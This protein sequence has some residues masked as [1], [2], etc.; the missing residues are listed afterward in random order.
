MASFVLC[1]ALVRP[2][3]SG[4]AAPHAALS[5]TAAPRASAPKPSLRSAFVQRKFT[6][7]PR[8]ARFE[9]KLSSPLPA[10][11]ALDQA[12]GA[13]AAAGASGGGVDSSTIF[14]IALAIAV[15]VYDNIK[16]P[17]GKKR[18]RA[19]AEAQEETA[20]APPVPA[21]P[22]GVD[23]I[24][25]WEYAV[26]TYEAV[27]KE[28]IK[29]QLR[30]SGAVDPNALLFS[31]WAARSGYAALTP[32]DLEAVVEWGAGVKL[33]KE[34]LA[35]QGQRQ[36]ERE[37]AGR[38]EAEEAAAVERLLDSE[39]DD[40]D[41]EEEEPLP[42]APATPPRPS[43]LVTPAG[44]R[45]A[46]PTVDDA[47]ACRYARDSIQAYF[48]TIGEGVSGTDAAALGRVLAACFPGAPEPARLLEVTGDPSTYELDALDEFEVTDY[49]ERELRVIAPDV[50][51]SDL[52]SEGELDDLVR[53]TRMTVNSS[54]QDILKQGGVVNPSADPVSPLKPI[55]NGNGS[56]NGNGGAASKPKDVAKRI[57]DEIDKLLRD[58]SN[59]GKEDD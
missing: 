18:R 23:P 14:L 48:A 27:G 47:E 8:T 11:A 52:F 55:A 32:S 51:L 57:D 41:L 15:V 58:D 6:C 22:T 13:A 39:G 35:R 44:P 36:A 53:Q 12:A 1:P 3:A 38:A 4:S 54:V 10:R 7:S 16:N 40:F 34:G 28:L 20:A 42:P 21:G 33:W 2:V 26:E 31:A 59:Y 25:F 50:K 46:A 19:A 17:G 37:A 43:R 5:L 24:E 45:G 56:G 29:V 49:I 30:H 9:W